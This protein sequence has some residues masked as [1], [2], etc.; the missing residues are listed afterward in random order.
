M[1]LED[2]RKYSVPTGGTPNPNNQIKGPH[3]ASKKIIWVIL[4]KRFINQSRKTWFCF[5]FCKE[6]I[7]MILA[8]AQFQPN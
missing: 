1:Q 5:V 8:H 6:I 3:T 2:K 4:L 7:F